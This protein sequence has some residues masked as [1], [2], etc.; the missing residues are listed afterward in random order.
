[1]NT[2]MPRRKIDIIVPVFNEEKTLDVI[3]EKLLAL[4]EVKKIIVVDDASK[5]NS[6]Q[7]MTSFKKKSTRIYCLAHHSNL[8]KG[9][10]IKSGLGLVTSDYFLIQDADLEYDPWDISKLITKLGSDKNMAVFGSR[11]KEGKNNDTF[12]HYLGNYLLTRVFN[13]LYSQKLTDVETCYKLLPTN[14]VRKMNLISAHFEFEPEIAAKLVLSG[15]KI[16]EV[17][18]KY[19]GRWYNQGKKIHPSDLLETV[20]MMINLKFP[21]FLVGLLLIWGSIIFSVFFYQVLCRKSL[22]ICFF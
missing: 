2:I 7:I 22:L 17:P 9:T 1:M 6:L 5:D 21:N 14:S 12:F 3:L 11:F 16:S 13:L 8:G 15:V 4:K 19:K 18:I 10:A 20:F